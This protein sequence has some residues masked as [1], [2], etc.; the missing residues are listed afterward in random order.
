MKGWDKRCLACNHTET[1]HG[2]GIHS[3]PCKVCECGEFRPCD[4]KSCK[5]APGYPPLASPSR[6][7]ATGG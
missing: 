4:C 2:P 7:K 1:E 6:E 3:T 5:D